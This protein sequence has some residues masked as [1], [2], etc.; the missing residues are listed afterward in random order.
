MQ[1][2][3]PS[4]YIVKSMLAFL[5]VMAILWALTDSGGPIRY[6]AVPPAKLPPALQAGSADI[7]PGATG[8]ARGDNHLYAL[9]GAN[10]G[11]K[12]EILAI[13]RI[14]NGKGIEIQYQLLAGHEVDEARVIRTERG[15]CALYV[16]RVEETEFPV[17][18]TKMEEGVTKL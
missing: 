9:I 16:F 13:E 1:I 17:R 5:V 11:E 8:V 3:R 4:K 10:P 12:A 15:T 14:K 6:E 2:N 18:F 7:A